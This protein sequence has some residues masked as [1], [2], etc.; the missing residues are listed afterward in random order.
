ME[1]RQKLNQTDV[2]RINTYMHVQTVHNRI[3]NNFGMTVCIRVEPFLP[4]VHH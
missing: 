2:F 4:S 3:V 1:N